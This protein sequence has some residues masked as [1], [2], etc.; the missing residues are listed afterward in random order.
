MMGTEDV[1]FSSHLDTF[2][3]WQYK[4]YSFLVH[5]RRVFELV[6]SVIELF[7][8]AFLYSLRCWEHI[9]H[10][11]L[12]CSFSSW[13]KQYSLSKISEI[14]KGSARF[15]KT[16]STAWFCKAFLILFH[17]ALRYLIHFYHMLLISV[18]ENKFEA[19]EEDEGG[20]S[21]LCSSLS[22]LSNLLDF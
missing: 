13:L 19:D 6:W 20:K 21:K 22:T 10:L 18:P 2:S 15:K 16:I 3:P 7:C 4:W 5:G 1:C 11:L 17:A 14:K 12:Y 8:V 9:F